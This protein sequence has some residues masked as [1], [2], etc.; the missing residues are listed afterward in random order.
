MKQ[1][2]EF[3]INDRRSII[4][5][6]VGDGIIFHGD[7]RTEYLNGQKAPTEKQINDK[8]AELNAQ[9][10]AEEYAR[11]RKAEFPTIEECVHA[12]LDDDLASLQAK[13]EK[14]KK[15]YPKA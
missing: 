12:I 8:K 7:G 4:R 14:I 5:E 6:L 11:K 3:K 13:R 1:L 2:N 10:K 9:Y 15:K